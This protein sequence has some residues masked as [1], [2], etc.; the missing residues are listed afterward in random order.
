MSMVVVAAAYF[1]CD[2]G[3]DCGGGVG[4]NVIVVGMRDFLFFVLGIS[5]MRRKIR[6]SYRV[7]KYIHIKKA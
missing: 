4:A 1:V 6:I 5:R 7:L 2:Y 3:C